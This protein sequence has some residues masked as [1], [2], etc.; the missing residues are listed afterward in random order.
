[1]N[2]T[3]QLINYSRLITKSYCTLCDFFAI[4][5]KPAINVLITQAG[6]ILNENHYTLLQNAMSIAKCNLSRLIPKLSVR[7]TQYMGLLSRAACQKTI[8]HLSVRR[9]AYNHRLKL[10]AKRGQHRVLSAGPIGTI[11]EGH[12]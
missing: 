10:P 9:K 8:G 11:W 4:K 12:P 3:Q 2:A 6:W 1:M 5:E 7:H